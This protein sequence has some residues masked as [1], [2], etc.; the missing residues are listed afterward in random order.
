MERS[1]CAV[2][3]F[4][5]C[6]VL[7]DPTPNVACAYMFKGRLWCGRLFARACALM[8]S[9]ACFGCNRSLFEFYT[10]VR[11]LGSAQMVLF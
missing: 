9:L 3:L 1:G 11:G 2:R 5:V 10:I 4:E 8:W 6:R 7:L